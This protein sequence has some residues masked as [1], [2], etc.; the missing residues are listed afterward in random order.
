[1]SGALLDTSV[2]IA[3]RTSGP[4]APP[5]PASVAISLLSLGELRAGVLLARSEDVRREREAQLRAVRR[6]FRPLPLDERVVER[7]AE[8]LALARRARRVTKASDLLIAATAL[9]HERTLHTL[10]A[11]Q[12]ELVRTAGGS[13]AG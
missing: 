5:P 7:Y 10:D 1:M 6:A 11:A 13:V 12:A 3:G 9:A 4:G 8:L 2:L